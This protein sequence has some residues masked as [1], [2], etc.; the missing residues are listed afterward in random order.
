MSRVDRD[1]L[2]ASL[3]SQ[4]EPKVRE[5]LASGAVYGGDKAGLVELWLAR[6]DRARAEA[7]NLEQRNIARSAKNAA[8]AAAIAAI[9]AAIAAVIALLSSG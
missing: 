4:G 3:E 1:K 2:F 9:I 8:W 5:D 7:S 6:K